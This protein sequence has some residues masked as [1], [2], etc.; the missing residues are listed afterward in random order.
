MAQSTY[1]D[2]QGE[3]VPAKYVKPYDKQRDRIALRIV[4]RWETAQASLRR[5]K[6]ETMADIETLRGMAE[7]TEGVNLGG[8]KGNIQ[9]RS[10]D[11]TV[12]VAYDV[13]ART[14]FDERL[15]MAQQLITEAV[16]ELASD[17]QNADLAE[18][19]TRA[20]TPRSS[21]RLDMQRVRELRNYKVKHPKW[22]QACK[23]IS[24]CE[25]KIGTREYIRVSK[26]KS[27]DVRPIPILLDL[28]VLDIHEGE[29]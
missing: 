27:G 6:A 24:E 28:A 8:A 3:K 13:Q 17:A 21:G 2:P 23:I 26:R 12:T 9:F 5:V 19:A 20:F 14:E 4:K 18:I 1:T 10:F 22:K 29:V 25:R 16:R 7:K 15:G 11:G